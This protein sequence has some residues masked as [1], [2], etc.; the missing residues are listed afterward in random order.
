MKLLNQ[1]LFFPF[2]LI[3]YKNWKTGY[4]WKFSETNISTEYVCVFQNNFSRKNKIKSEHSSVHV[5]SQTKWIG[6]LY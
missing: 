6:G 3:M 1:D 5:L 2:S 4:T